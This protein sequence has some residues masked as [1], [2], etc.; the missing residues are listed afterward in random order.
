MK[1]IG[2][3]LSILFMSSCSFGG[4]KGQIKHQI[5]SSWDSEKFS[6]KKYS[7]SKILLQLN[8]NKDGSV[9]KLQ[10]IESICGKLT[11]YECD[12]LTKSTTEAVYKTSPIK[13]LFID[14]YEDWKEIN[15]VF[16]PSTD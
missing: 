7:D 9:N 11:K 16:N 8:L 12:K 10:V 5:T 15:L 2:I 1:K 6:G 4:N 3:L 13:N 14:Q